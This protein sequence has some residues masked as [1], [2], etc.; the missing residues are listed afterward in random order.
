M[1]ASVQRDVNERQVTVCEEKGVWT[2]LDW[3]GLGYTGLVKL[4]W[5]KKKR[6]LVTEMLRCCSQS[7]VV[8]LEPAENLNL[9]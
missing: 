7:F 9:I 2:G 1:L 3:I 5:T 4:R 6:A 8:G